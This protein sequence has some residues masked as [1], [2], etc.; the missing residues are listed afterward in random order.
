MYLLKLIDPPAGSPDC[1]RYDEQERRYNWVDPARVT[2]DFYDTIKKE[3]N[4]GKS[5]GPVFV[6]DGYSVLLFGEIKDIGEARSLDFGSYNCENS[7]AGAPRREWSRLV[8]LAKEKEISVE[9]IDGAPVAHL[10]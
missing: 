4:A 10:R 9:A 8:S 1:R 3:F 7:G 6:K 5:I 2:S